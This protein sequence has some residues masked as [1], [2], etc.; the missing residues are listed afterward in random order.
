MINPYGPRGFLSNYPADVIYVI[1]GNP[2]TKADLLR[3]KRERQRR[4]LVAKRRNWDPL[5]KPCFVWVFWTNGLGG[6]AG[7]YRG[8]WLYI[9][10]LHASWNIGTKWGDQRKLAL[11]AMGLFP[12]GY[13]PMIENFNPWKEA[14]A[15]MYH[16]PTLKRPGKQGMAIAR[17]EVSANG[18]QILDITV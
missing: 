5:I 13:L 15:G 18:R 12:C 7:F 6:E 10:T 11:K 2:I 3:A 17:A 8:W 4:Q 16:R 9:N 14:F 1:N